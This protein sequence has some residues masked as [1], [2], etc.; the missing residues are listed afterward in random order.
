MG[1]LLEAVEQDQGR[2]E[3]AGGPVR[4]PL[5]HAH[6]AD[7][8]AHRVRVVEVVATDGL[9]DFFIVCDTCRWASLPHVWRPVLPVRCD[10][11]EAI[12]QGVRNRRIYAQVAANRG[13]GG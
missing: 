5:A 12:R 8:E 11:A 2:A 4:P 1:A 9:R 7:G 10:V 13:H 3:V 6:G